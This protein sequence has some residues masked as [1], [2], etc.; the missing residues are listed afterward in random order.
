MSRDDSTDR[1]ARVGTQRPL[2]RS[3]TSASSAVAAVDQPW[4]SAGADV[5]CWPGPLP[6]SLTDRGNARLFVDLNHDRFRHAEGV[7]WL[8]RDGYRWKRDGAEKAALWAAGEMGE[9][10]P[11]SDTHGFFNDRE[12]QQ[13]RRR[14]LSTFGM[15]ALLAH[16]EASPDLSVSP[17]ALDSDAYALCTPAGVVDLSTGR[18][19]AADPGKDLHS[20]ATSVA[21]EVMGIPRWHR[22]LSDI[23]GEG[24]DGR[25]M[26][27][28]L[29]VL[30][31]YSITGDVGAQVLPFLCG[32]GYNGKSVLL[33]TMMQLFGDY[34][35]TAP[36]GFLMERGAASESLSDLAE[37]HGRRLIVCSEP[38]RGEKFDETRVNFLTGGDR[39]K[40]R[41]MQES[42]SFAP[43]HHLW[44]MG[45]QRPGVAIGGSSFWRRIR[46]LPLD[47]VVP[48]GRRIDNLA[49]ELVRDEGPGILQWLVEGAGRYLATRGS[50][51][52]PDRVRRANTAYSTSEEHIAR[53]I[54]N[55]C[56]R[57]TGAGFE[58][59]VE[60]SLLYAAY[61]SWCSA[62][63]GIVPA[64]PRAFAV[65]VRR[66]VG[67]TSPAEMIKSNGRK[68]YPGIALSE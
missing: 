20:R 47:R 59:R 53:F 21:P 4:P 57:D 17:D 38:R 15:K 45:N 9:R 46:L 68:Y 48:D 33:D 44:I 55:R 32:E 34:A 28:F 27:D 51:E 35:D 61:S 52:G 23:F 62:Q 12:L 43:T 6:G 58:H 42:F 3:R 11:A 36:S 50:L 49:F 18:M 41:R 8:V 7:G 22:F 19:R 66:E 37:L 10:M 25:N 31:G 64:R 24:T 16:A 1:G 60:Q 26:I 65:R 39:I 14:T 13:H 63:E 54:E 5:R 67:L 56:I 2:P 40:A 29:Q 30:L